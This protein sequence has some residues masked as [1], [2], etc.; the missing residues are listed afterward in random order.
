MPPEIGI[1]TM[2]SPAI[3]SIPALNVDILVMYW[4]PNGVWP[5]L[6]RKLDVSLVYRDSF[7]RLD[8]FEFTYS[9]QAVHRTPLASGCTGKYLE[10]PPE[11]CPESSCWYAPE[12]C[13]G[14][15][16]PKF[17]SI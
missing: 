17:T 13:H 11:V 4:R 6:H 9:F 3:L 1:P 12:V 8:P 15:V 16:R 2:P 10:T 7:M 5:G 14:S